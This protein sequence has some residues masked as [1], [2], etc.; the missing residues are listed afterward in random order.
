MVG[1]VWRNMSGMVCDKRMTIVFKMAKYLRP[2]S[3]LF[4]WSET[5]AQIKRQQDLLESTEM[6][7]L[8]WIMGIK[9]I[10]RRN[11]SKGR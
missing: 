11:K 10:D 4:C 3:Y 2:S 8:S 6:R 1:N 5:R 7:M 9:G